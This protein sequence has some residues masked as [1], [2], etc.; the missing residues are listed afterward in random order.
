MIAQSIAAYGSYFACSF[1]RI[2]TNSNSNLRIPLTKKSFMLFNKCSNANPPLTILNQGELKV[3]IQNKNGDDGSMEQVN[4]DTSQAILQGE[5]SFS[6]LCSNVTRLSNPQNENWQEFYTV[7]SGSFKN[8]IISLEDDEK[9]LH[10]HNL[11]K[12]KQKQKLKLLLQSCGGYNRYDEETRIFKRT[13]HFGRDE[14]VEKL[15]TKH[16]DYVLTFDNVIKIIAICLRIQANIP[17][18]HPSYIFCYIIFFFFTKQTFE[19]K[20]CKKTR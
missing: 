9:T 15:F 13:S 17:T 18:L 6:I 2:N 19:D 3:D 16:N 10:N 12:Q 5:S 11:L 14:L 20:R 4:K 7:Q 1:S 8:S